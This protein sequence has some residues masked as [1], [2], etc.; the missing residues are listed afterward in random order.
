[1]AHAGR[2][3]FTCD[4]NVAFDASKSSDPDGDV[5]SFYWTFGDGGLGRGVEIDHRYAGPGSYPATL[6]VDDGGELSNSTSRIRIIAHVNALPEAVI[7]V[8]SRTVCAGEMV[9]FDAGKS[10]DA[11]KGLLRK[12]VEGINPVRSYIKGGD[13]RIR[14]G[15]TDDSRLPCDTGYAETFIHVIDAPIADAGEDR[16]VCANTP[17]RFDGTGSMGGGRRIKSYEW[18]FG[19][20]QYGV[21]AN[22]T[23]VY[24]GKG[25]YSVRLIITVSGEGECDNA[26]ED[27]AS[28][29][30]LAAPVAFFQAKKTACAEESVS[31]D[32]GASKAS[33][34]DIVDYLWDF[35]DGTQTTGKSV[36]H[37]YAE[38]GTYS[39][40]LGIT[41]DSRQSCKTA[42]YSET[43]TVNSKPSPVI[44]VAWADKPPATGEYIVADVNTILRFSGAES[45]D[46]DGHIRIHNWDLGDGR[47]KTGPFVSHHYEKPG[48]YPVNLHIVDNSDSGCGEATAGLLVRVREP[49]SLR[50]SGPDVICAGRE[51]AF[52]VA[53]GEPVEWFF[54]DGSTMTGTRVKKAFDIPGKYQIRARSGGIR[55]PAL[56]VWVRSLPDLRLPT[57]IDVF[58]EDRLEIQPVFDK[59]YR[60]PL[61]FQWD[62]GDGNTLETE[63]F[64][65]T[66]KLPGKYILTLLAAEKDGP[67]C[68]KELRAVPVTV[69]PPPDGEIQVEPGT[70]FTGGARDIAVFEAVLNSDAIHWNYA[71]DFGDGEKAIGRRVVHAYR[72]SGSFDAAVTLSDPLRKTLRTYRFVKRINVVKREK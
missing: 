64:G 13:Y 28:I 51:T 10:S 66:Y 37:A 35:G 25:T 50:I 16:S 23:H 22:P 18:E 48:E 60:S 32:A 20:G 31:F 9:L 36:T 69:H 62:T 49:A 12:K 21:G 54:G 30:V 67:D 71:W 65:H 72:K 68:L 8:N 3:V 61:R 17:V 56:D 33:D 44:E 24:A 7:D 70:I 45:R 53:S 58:P 6:T 4:Q 34:G 1:V 2:D 57:Q 55:I 59:S 41:T 26:S 52:E 63:T 27:L 29:T 47:K 11:E 19:D 15:V 5:L 14:L 38:P 46:A 42:E 40:V 43:V 39:T